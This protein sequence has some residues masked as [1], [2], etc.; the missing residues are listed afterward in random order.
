MHT[1]NY[2]GRAPVS[3]LHWPI[4][5]ERERGHRTAV[6]NEK[7]VTREVRVVISKQGVD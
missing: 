2:L 7:G 5:R 3:E 4:H 6:G 1:V